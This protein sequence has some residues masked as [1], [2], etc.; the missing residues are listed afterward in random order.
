[1]SRP[2]LRSKE[3]K[4]ERKYAYRPAEEEIPDNNWKT[5]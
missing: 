5:M 1:M 3:E 2:W 4:K